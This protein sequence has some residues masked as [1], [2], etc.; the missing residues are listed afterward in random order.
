ML[1]SDLESTNEEQKNGLPIASQHK[2]QVRI[3]GIEYTPNRD[4]SSS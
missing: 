1:A 4:S 2:K 3:E